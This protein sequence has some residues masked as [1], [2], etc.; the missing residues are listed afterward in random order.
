MKL[1]FPPD[2]LSLL[3]CK[4]HI[5]SASQ[6]IFHCSCSETFENAIIDTLL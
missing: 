2:S 6:G 5:G 1:I 3:P 4:T